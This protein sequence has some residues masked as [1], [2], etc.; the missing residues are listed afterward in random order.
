MVVIDRFHCKCLGNPTIIVS[1]ND[2]SP[3]WRQAIIRTN[4]G[5]LLIGTLGTNFSEILSDIH[6]FSFKK[7]HLNMSSAKIVAILSRPQC[8]KI[9]LWTGI[10]FHIYKASMSEVALGIH[11]GD[12]FIPWHL[13]FRF[14]AVL[15]VVK[16]YTISLTDTYENNNCAFIDVSYYSLTIP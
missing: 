1:D 13:L 5:I 2:L 16:M 9:S 8:D 12:C 4:A 6:T 7:M 3:G 15:Y 14:Q 11:P 10:C